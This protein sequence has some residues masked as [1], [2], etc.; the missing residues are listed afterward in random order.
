MYEF[1]DMLSA[2]QVASS[3]TF[4]LL[5]VLSRQRNDLNEVSTKFLPRSYY[6]ISK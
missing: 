3:S 1:S 6:P 2:Q 4:L 5:E